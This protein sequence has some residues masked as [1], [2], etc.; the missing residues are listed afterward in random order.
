MASS[1][2]SQP[3]GTICRDG[4]T[5]EQSARVDYSFAFFEEFT[6]FMLKMVIGVLFRWEIPKSKTQ[7]EYKEFKCLLSRTQNKINPINSTHKKTKR[8]WMYLCFQSSKMLYFLMWCFYLVILL[9]LQYFVLWFHDFL[10]IIL[11]GSTLF[12]SRYQV[13]YLFFCWTNMYGHI[14]SYTLTC[15]VKIIPK[16]LIDCE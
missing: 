12:Y 8:T 16:G 9:T 2:P 11:L 14:F 10:W 15:Q 4:K 13:V 3:D 6:C 5:K 7:K 1:S